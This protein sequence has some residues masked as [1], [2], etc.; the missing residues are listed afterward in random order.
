MK[1]VQHGYH[2]LDEANCWFIEEKKRIYERSI[3]LVLLLAM[4]G[5]ERARE[6]ARRAALCSL[7]EESVLR[8]S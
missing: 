8:S 3:Q 4:M 2:Q 1:Q 6:R 7:R 5:G